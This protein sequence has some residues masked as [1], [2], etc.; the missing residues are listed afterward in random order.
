MSMDPHRYRASTIGPVAWSIT[1]AA[2]RRGRLFGCASFAA[3]CFR[4]RPSSNLP[5]NADG[6]ER[7]TRASYSWSG[8]ARPSSK[9]SACRQYSMASS[10]AKC[11]HRCLALAM[12]CGTARRGSPA[13]AA[14]VQW[15]A[16][17][18]RCSSR[19]SAWR[20]SIASAISRC[21]RTR[22]C[23]GELLEKRGPDQ[24]VPEREPVEGVLL[25]HYDTCC[26]GASSTQSRTEQTSR[27][28]TRATSS[29]SNSRPTTA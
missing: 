21:R 6:L 27:S 13:A 15:Y 12:T 24:C 8:L 28:A 10:H 4:A 20:V 23:C 18:E 9:A 19:L 5:A 7:S 29:R 3:N 26:A 2:K 1:A 22:T 14:S 25:L 11:S 16:S 17:A